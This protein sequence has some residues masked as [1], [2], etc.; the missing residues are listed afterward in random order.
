M[1]MPW[2]A[3]TAIYMIKRHLLFV[4]QELGKNLGDDWSFMGAIGLHAKLSAKVISIFQTKNKISGSI[5]NH[6]A[7]K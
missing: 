5:Q 7:S 4:H 6:G 2:H 1:G 3:V